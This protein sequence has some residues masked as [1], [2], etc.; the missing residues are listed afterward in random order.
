MKTPEGLLLS[1]EKLMLGVTDNLDPFVGL[2]LTNLTRQVVEVAYMMGRQDGT[3]SANSCPTCP[4]K[5]L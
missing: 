3:R 5:D 2:K 1:I 4:F